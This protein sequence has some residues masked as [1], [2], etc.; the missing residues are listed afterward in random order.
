[1]LRARLVPARR[2]ACIFLC[3]AV[4][5]SDLAGQNVRDAGIQR[6]F[7]DV[8]SSLYG[9]FL[10]DSDG[11]AWIGTMGSGVY[12]YDGFELKAYLPEL[13]G[14]MVVSIAEDKDG[15]VWMA[16]ASNG[17]FSYDK[18]TGEVEQFE[19]REEDT[20]S[21]SS[22][23]IPFQP[24]TLCIDRSN[25]IWIATDGGG[26]NRYDK[27]TDTWT[28]YR[29]DPIDPESLS[30]DVVLCVTE[31]SDGSIWAGTRKGGL[32]RLDIVSNK[33]I[34]YTNEPRELS[35]LSDNWVCAMLEDR[36][37]TLW[38]G[39]KSGGL[40]R[41]N[42]E[43]GTFERF[44]H[45]PDKN[46][47]IGGNEVWSLTEDSAG[48][49]WVCHIVGE[50][51]GLD[52]VLKDSGR[53]SRFAHYRRNSKT[54]S[55]NAVTRIVE[56]PSTGNLW[57]L[58]DGGKIDRIDF[59]RTFRTVNNE[60]GASRSLSDDSVLPIIETD[61][62]SIWLGTKEGGLNRIDRAND[63]ATSFTSDPSQP[64]SLP[65]NRVTALFEDSEGILWVGLWDGILAAF[66]RETEQC[67]RIFQH[68][69][70]DPNSPLASERIKFILEDRDAPHILWLATAKGGLQKLDKNTLQFDAFESPENSID[71]LRP[72][73]TIPSLWDDGKGNLWIPTYGNGLYRQNKRTQTLVRYRNDKTDPHSI[74]SDTIYEI[75]EDPL[76]GYWIA[77]KGGISH[78]DPL[79]NRFTNF[80]TNDDG[81]AIGAVSS[82]VR[83]DSG[84]LWLATAGQGIY[85]FDPGSETFKQFTQEDGLQGDTFFWTSRL[86]TDD[87]EI[88]FGGSHGL[89]RFYP[90][91]IT[92]N[93]TPAPVRLTAFTQGGL[94]IE[95]A[96]ASERLER[97]T[98]DWHR[99]FFEFQFASLDF[100]SPDKTQ[101]AYMLEGWDSDWY[102]SGRNPFGRYSGLA[103]GEYT[104]KLKATNSDGYWNEAAIPLTIAI[105]SPFW[106]S[107]WF[108]YML[109]IVIVLISLAIAYYVVML[110]REV[111]QRKKAEMVSTNALQ[112]AEDASRAKDD[113]LAVMSHEMRTPLNPIMAFTEMLRETNQQEPESEYLSLIA[114]AADRQ[115]E[116]IDDTLNYSRISQGKI[117]PQLSAFD[118]RD[119]CHSEI[120]NARSNATELE[121]I[122]EDE[123]GAERIAPNQEVISDKGMLQSILSNLIGNACKYTKSGTVTL[124]IGLKNIHMRNADFVFSVEDTG[125][126]MDDETLRTIFEAF[127]QAD[128]S[129]TRQFQGAG[130]GLAI[131]NRLT[132]ALGG[133]I[134]ASSELGS[135][136]VF[137]CSIPVE[138]VEK[139]IP[140]ETANKTSKNAF[141][142]TYNVLVVDD[143]ADN[144]FVARAFVQ[145]LGGI[146]VNAFS[147]NEA[148]EKCQ[149]EVFDIILMDLSM[150]GMD[151][152]ETTQAIR[153]RP[154]PNRATPII[155]VTADVTESIKRR[156]EQEGF[157]AYLPKPLNLEEFRDTLERLAPVH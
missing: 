82:I 54:V 75:I 124:R 152:F 13:S 19:N 15:L 122:L 156:C 22:D 63:R 95:G 79:A 45:D 21:L 2:A 157:D 12:R 62:G 17:I 94:P 6:S 113:F 40:N 119:F 149:N 141:S 145:R 20:N 18:A 97:V 143:R 60:S 91:D 126:G 134:S 98:L 68:D 80:D 102:H 34:R 24:Q 148:L 112:E 38:V 59:N 47:S 16:T 87:G 23:V 78:F 67:A 49:L 137:N 96:G 8:Q 129:H 76:G 111:A 28:R 25:R 120:E 117:E 131:C 85:R 65:R 106:K 104:L 33:W 153:T 41:M 99:N 50:S 154:G 84:T 27:T 51:S 123:A 42:R 88:W 37:G 71:R 11:F 139:E 57:V 53:F 89:N 146:S 29:H 125:I 121:I 31:T 110:K 77:R 46:S 61:D 35:S 83:D 109:S 90:R 48:R 10:F 105:T 39:T 136:S 147:G 74:G 86:L 36:A 3:L 69:P 107:G 133:E 9:G 81:E 114:Q 92:Q 55:S 70:N 32:N 144:A 155:A 4:A 30:D 66:D 93:A 101:F 58:N 135:G 73:E 130:L 7:L 5:N 127:S 52:R 26:L 138:I 151:G 43:E 140:T 100:A 128:S 14:L 103:G 44:V 108:Y 115:L 56:N 116:L 64:N 150:P 132:E 142:K 72:N 118:L 1:M